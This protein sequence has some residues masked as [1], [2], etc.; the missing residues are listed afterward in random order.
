MDDMQD[1]RQ[2]FEGL[3]AE[4]SGQIHVAAVRMA[5]NT[6]DADDLAQDACLRAWRFFDKFIRGTNFR[7][8]LFKILKN[9]NINRN[10]TRGRIPYMD[11]KGLS[12]VE[13]DGGAPD[14][15][16]CDLLDDQIITAMDEISE[17]RKNA[18]KT[19]YIDGN[20][21]EEAVDIL[22]ISPN[23]LRIS[24]FRGRNELRKKLR[25]YA[26]KNYGYGMKK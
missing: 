14:S 15:R 18:I 7:A 1:L 17:E 9:T 24:L 5:G 19:V 21:Y 13:S 12:E 16:I 4:C 6:G 2:E 26:I 8:W 11:D 10:Q 23:A 3:L 20:S 25:D 22:G